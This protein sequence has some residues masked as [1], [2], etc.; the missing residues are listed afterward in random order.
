M[1]KLF[2]SSWLFALLSLLH[3]NVSYSDDSSYGCGL[4]SI[5]APQKSLVSTT[6]AMVVDYFIPSRISATTTGTSGCA[7]HSLV[8]KGKMPQHYAEANFENLKQGIAMGGG[9]YVQ[10]FGR[11]LGCSDQVYSR[12]SRAM[13]ENF[14]SIFEGSEATNANSTVKR[15]KNIIKHDPILAKNCSIQQA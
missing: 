3:G 13:Q 5:V 14:Q 8:M 6:T 12:F 1:R 4:G 7:R 9:A 11:T 2:A 15:V 10:V